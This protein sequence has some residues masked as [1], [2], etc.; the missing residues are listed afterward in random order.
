LAR[1]TE[2]GI[3]LLKAIEAIMNYKDLIFDNPM[4]HRDTS[5]GH[6]RPTYD[7][8]RKLAYEFYTRRGRQPGHELADWLAA[9]KQ[10]CLH[11]WQNLKVCSIK[12]EQQRA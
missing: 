4:F 8:I 9:E 6:D 7:E 5:D 3:T 11:Y 10:L 2:A 1:P 12:K